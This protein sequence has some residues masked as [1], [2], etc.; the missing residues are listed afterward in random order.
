MNDRHL[1]ELA[2]PIFTVDVCIT[3]G[4]NVL[5]LKRSETKKAFPGW[6]AL[7]GGHIEAN[8]DPLAAAIREVKEETGITVPPSGLR[9]KFV[10]VHHHLDRKEVYI[11]F[12]FLAELRILDTP[13]IGNSEG[14]L[15]WIEK[16][17]LLSLETV[18]PPVKYYLQHLLTGK[19]ILYNNSTW[20]NAT[21]VTVKSETHDIDA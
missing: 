19:G 16:K 14:T 5:M 10:A 18:L 13:V 11:V 9:Q 3:H 12:G 21:L 4:E 7:P 15:V 1:H 6:L 2:Q 8:E 17:P 20:N